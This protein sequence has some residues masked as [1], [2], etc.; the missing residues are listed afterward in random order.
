MKVSILGAGAMGSA[1]TIPYSEKNE[2]IL[3]G[4]EFDSEII[5]KLL[6]GEKHPRIDEMVKAS[7]ILDHS[8]L[9]EALVSDAIVIAVSTEGVIPLFKK[10]LDRIDSKM[11]LTIAK[12]LIDMGEIMTIPEVMWNERPELKDKICAI[13]GPSIAREVAKKLPTHVVYSSRGDETLKLAKNYL[14]TDY[15]RISISKDVIGCEITSALKNVYSIAIAW[16]GGME[17]KKGV[18]MNNLKGIIVTQALREIGMVVEAAGGRKDTVYGLTGIG[19]VIATFRGGR[20][21]MLGELLGKGY[22]TQQALEE[23]EKRGVGVVEG[24]VN[25]ERA[26]KL[27]ESLDSRGKIDLDDLRLLKSINDV[28]YHGRYAEEVISYLF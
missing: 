27:A 21:G 16:I 12:G 17:S 4:T 28:L 6:R 2:V 24:Y 14:Q 7:K 19:D 9:D 3:W 11:I 18:S 5:E 10:I 13:T 20:N 22:S 8:R 26:Y 23:L 15:Y 1:L 25:A